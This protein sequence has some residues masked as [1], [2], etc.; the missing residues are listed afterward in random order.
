MLK[1]TETKHL[2]MPAVLLVSTILIGISCKKQTTDPANTAVNRK[3]QFSLHTDKDFAGNAD[4]ITFTLFIQNSKNQT[5]W[6]SSLA[7]MQIKDIP[8]LPHKLTIEKSVPGNDHSLLKVGFRYSIEN[9]GTSAY[10]DSSNAG[11]IFKIVDFN[12]Q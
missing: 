6:D 8:R 2:S 3:I 12:F 10:I 4:N 7:T 5:L 9:T 11:E 1:M